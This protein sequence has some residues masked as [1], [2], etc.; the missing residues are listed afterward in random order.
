M[1][2]QTYRIVEHDGGW[3][4]Q[5]DGV[6]SETF[7]SHDLAFAAAC[8][9]AREQRTPGNGAQIT[10]EDEGGR[11]HADISRGDDRPITEVKS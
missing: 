2:K 8:R 10:W 11:W 9:A 6:F 3:A 1:T 4:Y 7:A 5:A